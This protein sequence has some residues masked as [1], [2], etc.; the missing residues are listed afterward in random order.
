MTEN[1]RKKTTL[2]QRQIMIQFM[3]EHPDLAQNRIQGLE[4]R[5]KAAHLWEQLAIELNSCGHG[6]T[7]STEKWMKSWRD[8]RLDVKSKASKLRNYQKGTGGGGPPASLQET[9]KRLL[10]LMGV[11]SVIGHLSIIDP[12]E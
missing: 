2:E 3:E 10:N 1:G 9:E 4:A 11:E 7:K 12:A 5:K 6:A 8:W